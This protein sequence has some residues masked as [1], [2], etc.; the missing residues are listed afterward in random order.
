MRHIILLLS[1]A[2]TMPAMAQDAAEKDRLKAGDKAFDKM[3]YMEALPH[4]QYLY[5]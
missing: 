1:L 5:R 4:F 2:I 3:Q